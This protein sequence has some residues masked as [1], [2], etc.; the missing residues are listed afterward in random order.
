LLPEG[1][2][3]SISTVPGTYRSWAKAGSLET[4]VANLARTTTELAVLENRSGRRVQLALEPEPDCLWDTADQLAQLFNEDLPRLADL[5]ESRVQR[6]L[7][8]CLDTCHQAVIFDSPL[9]SLQRVL[10]AQI[11]IA[12][13]Q[14]SAAPAFPC[15][16]DGLAQAKP[17]VDPCYLHQ[18]AIRQPDGTVTRFLDLP[19]ALE[20]ARTLPPESEL[21]THFHIPLCIDRWQ[22][23]RSTRDELGPEFWQTALAAGVTQ[24]EAET[25]TFDVLPAALRERPVA[26]NVAAELNWLHQ[27]LRP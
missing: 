19:E 25:Y 11:P 5:P 18:T 27:A 6:Y 22:A 12:K 21:R 8:V 17:F 20:A 9:A 1:V 24:F 10:R 16:E 3:G 2:T 13:I 23:M 14:V 4:I 26:D 7:G 15:T